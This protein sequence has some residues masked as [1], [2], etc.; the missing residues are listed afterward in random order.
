[1]FFQDD[2]CYDPE[3]EAERA[4]QSQI[5]EAEVEQAALEAMQEA[6]QPV[7]PIRAANVVLQIK[8]VVIQLSELESCMADADYAEL[9]AKMFRGQVVY[10]RSINTWHVFDG[11]KWVEDRAGYTRRLVTNE[12]AGEFLLKAGNL[13]KM[14]QDPHDQAR[15]Q[16][17]QAKATSLRNLKNLKNVLELAADQPGMSLTGDEWDQHPWLLCVKNGTLDLRTGELRASEPADFLKAQSPTT[18]DAN[19]GCPRW[20]RF[21][22]EVF[23]ADAEMSDFMQRLL[24]YILTAVV[25]DHVLPVLYG[26]GR[27]GKSV[28]LETLG[29]VLGRDG[30]T[31]IAADALMDA[32][33]NGSAA[34]P[35]VYLLRGKRLV[36]ASESNDGR[37]LNA[38]LVKSLTGGDTI[39]TRALYYAPVTFNPTHKVF[40]IT[41]HKPECDVDDEALWDRLLLIPF[42]LRFVDNPQHPAERQAYH[43]LGETLKQEAS[44]ILNWL[45][46]GC[47]SW[48]AEGLQVPA[49]IRAE[50]NEW[51]NKADPLAEFVAACCN[52]DRAKSVSGKRL[53]AAY[54]DWHSAK[55][56]QGLFNT[57]EKLNPN[58]FGL[59]I[60][61]RYTKKRNALGVAYQGITLNE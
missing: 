4:M 40:L 20:E 50:V 44:G 59:E 1:M 17:L 29:H 27:N 41:N 54:E 14:A 53:Y 10:D 21:V 28:M 39:T 57:G 37:S 3:I 15:V 8:P 25:R 36:W 24:G 60:S 49:V 12:L 42:G 30:A 18:F 23:D 9:F 13:Q 11:V 33:K 56:G 32:T 43:G 19:A 38:G 6:T 61:K 46:K 48:Q 51:R 16:S 5:E 35:Y 34:Q 55:H 52:E 2:D 31:T 7:K 22:S 45:V 26:L 58:A 47:L